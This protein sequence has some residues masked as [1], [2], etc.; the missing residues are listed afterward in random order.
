MFELEWWNADRGRWD[1][2]K[3]FAGDDLPPDEGL[4]ALHRAHLF[5]LHD[6]ANV[7]RLKNP[8]GE[9]VWVR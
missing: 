9:T 6:P 4:N 8:L 2:V 3:G 7:Y 1:E 5:K